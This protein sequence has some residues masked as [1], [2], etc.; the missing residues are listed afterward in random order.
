MNGWDIIDNTADGF[1]ITEGDVVYADK[2]DSK[3]Y[4]LATDEALLETEPGDSL[5]DVLRR[6]KPFEG[7]YSLFLTPFTLY[8]KLAEVGL[9]TA[10]S[11][12]AYFLN[13]EAKFKQIFER[14]IEVFNHLIHSAYTKPFYISQDEHSVFIMNPDNEPVIAIYRVNF[15]RDFVEQLSNAMM[16]TELDYFLINK[17]WN[18]EGKK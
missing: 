15:F 3:V 12:S 7:D 11:A 2:E 17:Y 4:Y 1:H 13:N 6:N 5:G 16:P 14:P 9:F 18:K 8:K 10:K